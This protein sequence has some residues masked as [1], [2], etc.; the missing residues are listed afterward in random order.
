VLFK[1]D[2]GIRRDKE[3]AIWRPNAEKG[4]QYSHVILLVG[5]AI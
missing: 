2:R 5:D 4:I 1:N 3:S